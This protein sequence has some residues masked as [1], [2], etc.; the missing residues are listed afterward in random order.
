MKKVAFIDVP[1]HKKTKSCNFFLDILYDTYWEKNVDIFYDD[2]YMWWI[3]DTKYL[4]TKE[5]YDIFIFWVIMPSAKIIRALRGKN[6]VYVPMYDDF[7]PYCW[8]RKYLQIANVRCISFCT[9]V[10]DFVHK[11]MWMDSLHV[12]Y[13]PDD[14]PYTIDYIGKKIYRRYRGD[15][16][17]E[18]V[19]NVLWDQSIDRLTIKNIPDPWYKSLDLD[20][21]DIK[22]YNISFID[23]FFT[24]HDEHYRSV[25]Q[26][27]IFIAPRSREGIWMS[28]LDALSGWMCVIWYNQATMNEYITDDQDWI[29]TDFRNKI[30]LGKYKDLWLAA[31][32]RYSIWHKKRQTY[33]KHII[34]FIDKEELSYWYS[35]SKFY[36][37]SLLFY[38]W[39][40]IAYFIRKIILIRRR[41]FG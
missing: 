27:N 22:K 17:W 11:N 36:L 40:Y 30:D 13:Y 32:E 8:Y 35:I 21:N 14:I 41:Y 39:K 16:S 12:Q 38:L 7:H 15:I 3:V 28:F 29:L 2:F 26:H 37:S 4:D 1:F 31:K 34:R 23:T 25:Y 20:P 18:M 33:K 24:E 5:K 10:H 6:I 19:Q 9:E